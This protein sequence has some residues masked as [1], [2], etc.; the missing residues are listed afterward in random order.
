MSLNLSSGSNNSTQYEPVSKGPH[1]ARCYQVI[2]LGHQTVE[3]QGTA[4]VVPKVRITWEICDEQMSDG[5]PF[6]ISKEYTASI[7]EKANLR[8]DLVAWGILGDDLRNFSL[9]SILNE[10]CQLQIAHTQKGDKTY[11]SVN[12]IVEVLKNTRVPELVN[13][14]VKFDIQ[15]FDHDV[16][17]SLTNYV[18]KKILMSKELEDHGIPMRKERPEPSI[19]DDESVPF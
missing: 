11:A 1:L 7:G 15:N 4:K 18:Q 3:W 13:P 16:F 5:R 6:S 10:P 14:I 8:K 9:D 17:D 12:G 19:E 2:D